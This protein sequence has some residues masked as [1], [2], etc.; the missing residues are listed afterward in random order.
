MHPDQQEELLERA[1][2][3]CRA[4]LCFFPQVC[5]R[6]QHAERENHFHINYMSS[7]KI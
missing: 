2:L 7:K 6:L 4:F 5:H 3:V 1:A